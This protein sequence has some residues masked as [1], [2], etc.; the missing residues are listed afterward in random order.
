MTIQ[1]NFNQQAIDMLSAVKKAI[2]AGSD[3]ESNQ[4]MNIS[5]REV[6]NSRIAIAYMSKDELTVFSDALLAI[7]EHKELIESKGVNN[8]EY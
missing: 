1:A 5:L 3:F 6:M 8:Y 2:Q 7:F 4:M